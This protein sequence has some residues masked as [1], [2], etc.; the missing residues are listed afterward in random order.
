MLRRG[1]HLAARTR[2]AIVPT[3]WVL[4]AVACKPTLDADPSPDGMGRANPTAK[5]EEVHPSPHALGTDPLLPLLNEEALLARVEAQR[6]VLG[7]EALFE[8]ADGHPVPWISPQE[9]LPEGEASLDD[10]LLTSLPGS[11]GLGSAEPVA[12]SGPRVNGNALGLFE[13]IEEPNQSEALDHFYRA[14]QQLRDGKD[15]DG[16]VR[17]LAYGGSHTDADVYTHYLR[18]YLQERFGDGG[19]GFVHVARPWK[20]YGHFDVEVDGA[21]YWKTEH[22]QR[23]SGRDD[24]YFGLLGAS[25]AAKTKKAFGKVIPRKGVVASNYELYF[26]KQ[27]RGG[28]FTVLVDEKPVATVKTR[29]AEFGPGYYAFDLP[30]AEHTVEIRPK[31]NGEVRMFGMTMERDQPGVVVDTLGIGGTRAANMLEWD[32]TTWGDNIQHR[33]PDLISLWYGTNEATD[34][35]QSIGAYEERLRLVVEKLKR[36]APEASCLLVGP[37]DFPLPSDSG[38]YVARPRIR[39]IVEVQERVAS[40]MG[41]GFWDTLAFMG[42]EMSMTTW[43]RALPPMAKDDHIHF[44]RRGYTRIGM[45]LVDAMMANFDGSSPLAITLD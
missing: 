9:E 29:A 31:G 6:A 25:L 34:T 7:H 39:E 35:N 16:K 3:V 30:E 45:G 41:C 26:L 42:G 43:V 1:S 2:T 15:P 22:A 44:T 12:F 36:A 17:I 5:P 10:D 24:G 40:E 38:G 18:T 27:P 21:K 23:R 32:E 14:L 13:P 4:A 19:H 33:A 28:S 11:S 20:W 37:G 8:D